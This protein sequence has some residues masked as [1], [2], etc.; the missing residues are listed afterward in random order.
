MILANDS[1]LSAAELSDALRQLSEADLI[2]L[3]KIAGWYIGGTSMQIDDLVHEAI[4]RAMEGTRRCPRDLH[5]ITFLFKTME[6]IASAEREKYDTKAVQNPKDPEDLPDKASTPE[7]QVIDMEER[8]EHI[9][10]LL[11]NDQEALMVLMR[12]NDGYGPEEICE[13]C[14]IDKTRYATIRRRIRRAIERR[15]SGGDYDEQ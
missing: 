7:L 13:I 15:E 1:Y 5:I 8:Q 12:I 2:R 4:V 6:S 14:E 11:G 3:Y 9:E 10:A